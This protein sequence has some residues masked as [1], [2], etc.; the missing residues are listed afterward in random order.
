ML[1]KYTGIQLNLWSHWPRPFAQPQDPKRVISPAQAFLSRIPKSVEMKTI[2]CLVRD[3]CRVGHWLDSFFTK[4]WGFALDKRRIS[5]RYQKRQPCCP[6]PRQK[7]NLCVS[8]GSSCSRAASCSVFRFNQADELN[9]LI[10]SN[11][12][13]CAGQYQLLQPIGSNTKCCRVFCQYIFLAWRGFTSTHTRTIWEHELSVVRFALL[14]VSVA[15]TLL[16]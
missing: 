10:Q 8:G 9:A 16:T 1:A 4:I 5:F 14:L 3:G 13:K 11:D 2:Y 15:T 12:I 7:T 6:A